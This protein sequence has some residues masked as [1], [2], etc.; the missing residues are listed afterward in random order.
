MSKLYP[1][2]VLGVDWLKDDVRETVGPDCE[3]E[4]QKGLFDDVLTVYL[5]CLNCPSR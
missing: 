4:G 3:K 5:R 2:L 1:E